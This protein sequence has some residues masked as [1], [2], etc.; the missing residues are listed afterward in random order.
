MRLARR[1]FTNSAR[2]DRNE[3]RRCPK[4]PRL[5][6]V[7]K[8]SQDRG[9]RD[10]KFMTL[11]ALILPSYSC[12]VLPTRLPGVAV[13]LEEVVLDVLEELYEEDDLLGTLWLRCI[14]LF[15][16]LFT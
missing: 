12:V 2:K 10:G 7:P 9:S 5:A 14:F 1:A 11:S 15:F 16:G 8:D 3:V 6:T 4:Y 13:V